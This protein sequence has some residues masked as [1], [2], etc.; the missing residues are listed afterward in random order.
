MPIPSAVTATPSVASAAADFDPR[1]S[2]TQTLNPKPTSDASALRDWLRLLLTVG[3]GHEHTHALL[4]H[5][6]SPD[7]IFSA[8]Q[9]TLRPLVGQAR[10]QAL[11]LPPANLA[12][13]WARL[14]EWL[15]ASADRRAL[16]LDDPDYPKALLALYDAPILL[17]CMGTMPLER[18][19][20]G[21]GIAVVGSRNPT[22]QGAVHARGF[23]HYFAQNGLVVISG[24]A[25]GIDAAAHEGA[26]SHVLDAAPPTSDA[27]VGVTVAVTGTGLDRVY[28]KQNHVLAHQIS[29]N[30]LLLSEFTLGTPPLP[31]H[32]PRRNRLIAA[33]SRGC[34][35]VEATRHSGSLIT[36]R[37]CADMGREVYALP[38]SIHA[39]QAQ[40]CHYLIK[41]GARLV[42]SASEVLADLYPSTL[43]GHAGLAATAAASTAAKPRKKTQNTPSA[44]PENTANSAAAATQN[45]ALWDQLSAEHSRVL[46]ALGL[47]PCHL[48]QLQQR[49]G[50]AT[51]TLQAVLFELELGNQIARCE[52][53]LF[54]RL[55]QI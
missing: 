48:D 28:P 43:A 24:L 39:P 34:L 21:L 5:F 35:V 55:V 51:A 11:Q 32:F 23:A 17:F 8:A 47:E 53:G 52:G 41:E 20:Y 37:L 2:S 49:T 45:L 26:L 12:E 27:A 25:S 3:M 19:D 1:P 31:H 50:L 10:A 14:Q 22:P 30:G 7:A 13:Q 9:A 36:A 15:A 6:G 16:T 40:G 38:G 29:Q 54:Q 42:E 33:L 4:R 46:Q 44:L 18:L